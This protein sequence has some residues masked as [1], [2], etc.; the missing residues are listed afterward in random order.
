VTLPEAALG[1]LAATQSGSLESAEDLLREL[2]RVVLEAG[3]HDD[4]CAAMG[5]LREARKATYAHRAH[6]VSSLQQLDRN[7]LYSRVL[8]RSAASWEITA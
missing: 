8:E 3:K 2:S 4:L 1:V 7:L 5:I 6:I